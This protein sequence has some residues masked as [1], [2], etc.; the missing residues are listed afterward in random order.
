M[1]WNVILRFEYRDEI[2]KCGQ[3]NESHWAVLSYDAVYI[4]VFGQGCLIKF[5]FCMFMDW[6]KT[7]HKDRGQCH[8][9]LNEQACP[10]KDFII[11]KYGFTVNNGT[12][13]TS[14]PEQAW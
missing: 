7:D 11:L 12:Q 8:T 9:I 2:L 14:I 10:I 3:S 13:V 4:W 5:F 6:A 1:Q